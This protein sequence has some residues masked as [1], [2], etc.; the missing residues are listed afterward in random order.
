MYSTCTWKLT[1]DYLVQ[2]QLHQ[3]GVV[4]S[5]SSSHSPITG[6]TSSLLLSVVSSTS[7][8]TSTTSG[9]RRISQCCVCNISRSSS[10]I[11]STVRSSSTGVE[12]VL[13]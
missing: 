13:S 6:S 2:F 1:K 4:P 9:T 8:V 5:R 3:D 11:A 10:S 7:T 12:L